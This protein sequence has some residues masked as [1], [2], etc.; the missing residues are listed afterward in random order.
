[1]S[2]TFLEELQDLESPWFNL[3]N[4]ELRNNSEK[5]TIDKIE[6]SFD[7]ENSMWLTYSR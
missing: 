7:I 6:K 1:M 5:I 4:E 3:F 2:S